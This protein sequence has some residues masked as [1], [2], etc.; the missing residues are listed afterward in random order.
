MR[1]D[2]LS[3]HVCSWQKAGVDRPCVKTLEAVVAAQ[4]TNRSCEFGDSF[5]R[6]R[7]FVR[8]NLA[9]KR[10]AEWFS[11]SQGPRAEAVDDR[12]GGRPDAHAKPCQTSGSAALL[13][14]RLLDRNHAWTKDSASVVADA[15]K[16]LGR[17]EDAKA[18]RERY[19]VASS[20]DLKRP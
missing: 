15:L 2:A 1:T 9:P 10:S 5:M 18:L 14:T 8:I 11:R 7:R 13:T 6:Q 4:Q 17:T 3:D 19:G 12:S 16:A 20:D